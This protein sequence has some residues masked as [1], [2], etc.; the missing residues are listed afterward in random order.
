VAAQALSKAK[1]LST[2]SLSLPS[3]SHTSIHIGHDPA[4]AAQP[5]S[6]SHT[7]H[8][9]TGL[10]GGILPASPPPP[11]PPPPFPTEAAAAAA[12][13][14]QQHHHHQQQQGSTPSVSQ[15][16]VVLSHLPWPSWQP[17]S[18]ATAG[19]A[20]VNASSSSPGRPP[21]IKVSLLL[22]LILVL[23]G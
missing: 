21:V 18:M 9:K 17:H 16:E 3:V 4:S 5:V 13:H 23:P 8:H 19:P 10:E 11:T 6:S 2:P 7:P 12:T 15:E 14:Q 1:P 22:T 20:G